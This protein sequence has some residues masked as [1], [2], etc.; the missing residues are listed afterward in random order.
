MKRN[1]SYLV[2]AL[3]ILLRARGSRLNMWARREA[4]VQKENN[5]NR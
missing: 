2:R 4:S 5:I 1:S 3:A